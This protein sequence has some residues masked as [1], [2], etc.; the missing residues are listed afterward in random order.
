MSQGSAPSMFSPNTVE[1]DTKPFFAGKAAHGS[2]AAVPMPAVIPAPKG[3]KQLFQ[4]RVYAEEYKCKGYDDAPAHFKGHLISQIEEEIV[5]AYARDAKE[6]NGTV[7]NGGGN[8]EAKEHCG[9]QYAPY[10]K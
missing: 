5:K 8:A 1:Q 4:Y 2:F 3:G 7:L 6:K 10:I 9:P